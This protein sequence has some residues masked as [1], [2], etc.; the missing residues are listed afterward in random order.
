MTRVSIS[1]GRLVHARMI[2]VMVMLLWYA[3]AEKHTADSNARAAH[4]AEL[5][6][7]TEAAELR[8]IAFVS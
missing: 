3:L 4:R 8:R 2:A 1:F 6:A 5:S 7:R